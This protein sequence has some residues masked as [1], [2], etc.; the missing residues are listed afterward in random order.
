MEILEIYLTN[1]SKI[2]LKVNGILPLEQMVKDH[3]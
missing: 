3:N 2:Q 1:L